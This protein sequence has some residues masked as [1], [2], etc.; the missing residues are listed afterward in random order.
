MV[1]LQVAAETVPVVGA[2]VAVVGTLVAAESFHVGQVAG[3]ALAFAGAL[4]T[5]VEALDAG[6]TDSGVEAHHADR[7]ARS[8]HGRLVV[9]VPGKRNAP[10][11]PVE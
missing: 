10:L 4:E 11:G 1:G 7:L 9:K 5:E 6:R 8:S 3:L 2:E